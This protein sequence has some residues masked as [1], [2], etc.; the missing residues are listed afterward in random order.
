MKKTTAKIITVS[1]LVQWHEKKELELSPKYQRNSVWN[2]KAKSYLIDTIVRGLPIPPIFM[3]QRVDVN[4]KTTNREIIDGQ[5]RVRSILEY[6]V[7]E[8]YA[9]KRSHNRLFGGKKYS[10]LDPDTQEAILEY[11][12]LAEVVT[13]KDE[14]VIYD[15]FARLNSNNIVL[16]S[17][18]IRNSKYW[19]EF[20]VLVYRLSSKYRDFFLSSKL[21]SDSDC[22][23]MRDSELIN[24][25]LILLLE[26]IVEETPTYI[27]NVY[28]KY[29]RDFAESDVVET[30]FC[31]I[32]D[33]IEGVY[34]YFNGTPGCF[35]NKNYFFTMYC[36]L[37]NQMYGIKNDSTLSRIS[38]F[39]EEN[40]SSNMSLVYKAFSQFSIDFETNTNDKDNTY[41]LYLE[42][43][44]F[45][46]N[47]K[48]RTTN[49]AEKSQRIHFLNSAIEKVVSDDIE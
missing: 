45:A 41:G 32:M 34:R 11:E 21:L 47:H 40:I 4:T 22:A 39:S 8:S 25:M 3:R 23:R 5:Q 29:D 20:K 18:E 13:E 16:N 14:S 38:V 43:N 15:M 7:S 35:K 1:D 42:Y 49:K 10:E 46:K 30:Q 6:V 24:S 17:Q 44:E 9:I 28:K 2:E 27:E 36:V 31:A 12:I 19:G 33:I 26:G 48:S 37:A